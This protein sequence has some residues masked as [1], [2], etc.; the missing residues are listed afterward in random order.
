MIIMLMLVAF[1]FI[2]GVSAVSNEVNYTIPAGQ[3]DSARFVVQTLK[4]EPYPAGVGDWF[5]VWIKVQNIGQADAPNAHFVLVEDYPFSTNESLVRDF[6]IIRGTSAAF[7]ER[8]AGENESQSNQVLLKYRLFVADNAAVG[9]YNLKLKTSADGNNGLQFT[10]D[11]PI[12]IGNTNADFDVA[13]Q[14]VTSNGISFTVVNTGDA[15]SKSILITPVADDWSSLT[16][17]RAVTIGRLDVGDSSTFSVNGNPKVANGDIHFDIKYTDSNGVRREL[18]KSV[19]VN[20]VSISSGSVSSSSGYVKWVYA[21]IG[22]F[23]GVFVMI[24]SRRIHK[25][26]YSG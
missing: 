21:L 18:T 5:D 24:I 25:K 15:I 16:G 7:R 13:L 8:T 22:V 20:G 26:K 4:Y 9:T 14:K 11:L 17:D 2:S 1:S 19:A 23:V 6:G 10:Y 3:V 12:S